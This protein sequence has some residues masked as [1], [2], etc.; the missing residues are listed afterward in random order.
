[1]TY[2]KQHCSKS[3]KKGEQSCLTAALVENIR[4]MASMQLLPQSAGLISHWATAQKVVFV[5]GDCMFI[6]SV[7]NTGT[8][9]LDMQLHRLSDL[10]E[11]HMKARHVE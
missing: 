5:P 6:T 7:D 10:C 11:N 9:Y 8:R 1:M 4:L 2:Q 3:A